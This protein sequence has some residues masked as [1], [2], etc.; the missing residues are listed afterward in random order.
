[1]TARGYPLASHRPAAF[2]T[3]LLPADVFVSVRELLDCCALA[4]ISTQR[5]RRHPLDADAQWRNGF[6]V[7]MSYDEGREMSRRMRL[8]LSALCGVLAVVVGALYVGQVRAEG[9]QERNEAIRRYGGELVTL[10]VASRTIEM[11]EVITA[12]D[13]SMRD[14]VSSLAPKGALTSVEDV[15]G[16]ELSV[17][18]AEGAPL[19]DLN[20]RQSEARLDIPSGH[21][22][23]SVP[24]TEKLGISS[25]V[26]QGAH[27]SAYRAVE[28]SSE[29]LCGDVTVLSSPDTAGTVS[30]R[31]FVTIAVDAACIAPVISASTA[32]DLRLVLPADDVKQETVAV[33]RQNVEPVAGA[34]Q[35]AEV[36]KGGRES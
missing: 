35:A 14:W 11:G 24:L 7:R 27:L 18:I 16:K 10:A 4:V 19:T 31:G 2:F 20:F 25:S 34:G 9:E 33:P 1:M 29:A 36:A 26:P 3:H 23:L 22:A 15:V 21:V 32:G 5:S 30:G 28:G 13:V 8:L 17:P 12:S 6:C